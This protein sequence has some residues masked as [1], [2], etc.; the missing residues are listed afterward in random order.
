MEKGERMGKRGSTQ[1]K[2]CIFSS[3]GVAAIVILVTIPVKT[4]YLDEN[5]DDE[6]VEF[7]EGFEEYEEGYRVPMRGLKENWRLEDGT[8]KEGELWGE[9]YLSFL[10]FIGF[11][12]G[13]GDITV[14]SEIARSGLKSARVH[15]DKHW[16]ICDHW[17]T[18]FRHYYYNIGPYD[19]KKGIWESGAWFYLPSSEGECPA[20]LYVMVDNHD[21][22]EGGQVDVVAALYFG[23]GIT[24]GSEK[25]ELVIGTDGK[26]V[27]VATDV[28]VAYDEWFYLSTSINTVTNR[29][30][31]IEYSIP[32]LNYSL[33]VDT[34]EYSLSDKS[35]DISDGSADQVWFYAGA[36]TGH[37]WGRIR[38]AREY[39][40]YIDDWQGSFTPY[41]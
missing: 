39:T 5:I 11:W 3:I 29:W 19:N 28:P 12:T 38:K 21:H 10:T 8:L 13:G 6:V 14:T 41:P 16:S 34:S 24:T 23:S 2:K 18:N 27:A 15:H 1:A 4:T 32:S 20:A 36:V 25:F 40:F 17:I 35:A 31:G 30:V 9:I 33:A 26:L 37:D 7:N 22:R